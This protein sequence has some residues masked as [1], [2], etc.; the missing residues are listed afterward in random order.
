[1]GLL[2]EAGDT[3]SLFN[4]VGFVN[5]SFSGGVWDP[6]EPIIPVGTGFFVQKASGAANQSWARNFVVDCT[7]APV[8][9]GLDIFTTPPGGTTCQVFPAE[10]PIPA[11]FFGSGS[12]PFVGPIVFR[13]EPLQTDPPN[14]IWPTDTIVQRLA[15]VTLSSCSS[16]TVPIQIMALCLTSS[17]PITVNYQGGTNDQWNVRATLSS[18]TPQSQGLMTITADA[19]GFGGT[20]AASLPVRP[21]LIFTRRSDGL[22]RVLDAGAMAP[23]QFVTRNGHWVNFDPGTFNLVKAQP[24]MQVDHDCNP[25]TPPVTLTAGSSPNFIAGLR[26]DYCPGVRPSTSVR[27]TLTPEEARYASHGVAS[28]QPPPPDRDG[29][30]IPDDVDNCPD[31]YNPLQEDRDGDGVGEVCD[32][33]SDYFNPWQERCPYWKWEQFPGYRL[34]LN[35]TNHYGGDRASS[36]N[37]NTNNL[38]CVVADD[39]RS[40]GRPVVA[41]RW[42]GAYTNGYGPNDVDAYVLSFFFDVPQTTNFYSRPGQLLGTYIAPSASVCVSNPGYYGWD[43]LPIYQYEVNLRDT[44]LE[45]SLFWYPAGH[46]CAPRTLDLAFALGQGVPVV[47]ITRSGGNLTTTGRAAARWKVR[48]T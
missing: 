21:K 14:A 36:Y 5:Y 9:G 7:G 32:N 22:V 3:A 42:W 47:I 46:V 43:L 19:T 39:F 35:S 40:D 4:G 34:F 29:D 20:F 8:D 24:G 23:I 37:W 10:A 48:T 41:V 33:C 1:L 15:S 26:Y 27:K 17:L 6:D 2:A 44:C 38:Q 11:G 18:T 30:G 12:L 13:S 45:H 16:G 25:L 31:T 28:A